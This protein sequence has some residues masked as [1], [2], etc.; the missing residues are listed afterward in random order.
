MESVTLY[1]HKDETGALT[2]L[3]VG[4]GLS[5]DLVFNEGTFYPSLGSLKSREVDEYLIIR[6]G[7]FRMVAHQLD[8]STDPQA[9]LS[10]VAERAMREGIRTLDGAESLLTRLG[11]P[12]NRPEPWYTHNDD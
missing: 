12:S 5:G 7:D 6:T 9:L 11:I 4:V 8:C 1:K 3:T 10:A 2:T